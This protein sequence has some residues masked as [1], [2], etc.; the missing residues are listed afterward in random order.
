MMAESGQ[1]FYK[2]VMNLGTGSAVTDNKFLLT[3]VMPVKL[4]FTS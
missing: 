2:V 3:K 1:S 4:P